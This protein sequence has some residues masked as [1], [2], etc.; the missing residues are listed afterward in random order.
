VQSGDRIRHTV[1]GTGGYGDP[2]QRDPSSV[3]KDV[4]A[5]KVTVARAREVYGV[6]IDDGNPRIAIER[7]VAHRKS[8]VEGSEVAP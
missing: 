1:A 7:T 8:R 4:I 6:E 3:L 5:G 2:F